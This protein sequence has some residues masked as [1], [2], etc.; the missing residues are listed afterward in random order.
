MTEPTEIPIH[1]A[2]YDVPCTVLVTVHLDTNKVTK[3]QIS[4]RADY[5]GYFGPEAT[6]WEI[7]DAWG[8]TL[9]YDDADTADEADAVGLAGALHDCDWT[10]LEK[11]PATIVWGDE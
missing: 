9:D 5:A 4:P 3:I 6:L 10:L 7:H 8:N 1:S 11:L 2:V